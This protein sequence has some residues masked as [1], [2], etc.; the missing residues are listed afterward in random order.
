MGHFTALVFVL[1]LFLYEYHSKRGC[2]VVSFPIVPLSE[3]MLVV[4]STRNWPTGSVFFFRVRL[5]W[6]GW[7]GVRSCLGDAAMKIQSKLL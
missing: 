6:R 3:L 2:H 7:G 1:F 5:S 4:F